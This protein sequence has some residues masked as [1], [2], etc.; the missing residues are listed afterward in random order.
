MRRLFFFLLLFFLFS[1]N[2]AQSDS[3][4]FFL[5]KDLLD[6][7][8][9][10]EWRDTGA[11]KV[12]SASRSAKNVNDLPVP[13]YVITH[14]EIIRNH[15]TSL[16]DILKYLPGFRVSQPG[17]GET[18][19]IF[20]FRGLIGNYYT[21]ILINNVPVKPSVL[22]GMPLG[23][24]LPIRQA[25]RIEII[26]GPAAAVYGADAVTGVINIITK[27][28]EKGTF[29]R[30]DI[31][32]GEF[33]KEYINFTVGGKAGK[34]RNIMQYEFYGSKSEANFMNVDQFQE[35]IIDKE[36]FNPLYYLE[37]RGEK[38]NLGGDMYSPL[39]IT[40]D[41][42]ESHSITTD[43][44]ID[45]YYPVN[46][47]GKLTEP[48]FG[49]IPLSSNMIGTRIKLRGFT[50]SYNNMNRRM[51]SSLGRST[52]LFKYNN[53]QNFI[54]ESVQRTILSYEKKWEKFF[55]SSQ[56]S[57]LG[58]SM[59]NNSNYGVTFYPNTD[60]VYVYSASHD[61]FLEQLVIYTPIPSFEVVSGV[62]LQYSSNLPTTNYLTK[63]FSKSSYDPFLENKIEPDPLF[64]DFGLNPVT[65]YNISSFIQ[66]FYVRNKFNILA[67]LRHDKNSLYGNRFNPRLALLYKLGERT[68]LTA[69][70]GMAY[71]AP[72]S[73]MSYQSIAY[74]GGVNNDSINYVAIPNT[75]LEPEEFFSTEFGIR[76]R[77]FKKFILIFHSI[78]AKSQ[79]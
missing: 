37:Q 33:G 26:Y 53:S 31:H 48:T 9:L 45:Q 15:Y 68:T 23:D 13:I 28:A 8:N 10:I 20:Q 47:E 22:A 67:G 65:F 6:V 18:G 5:K 46:Y 69:S 2:W 60:K 3:I 66:M 61:I 35:Q 63:P 12:I 4:S 77:F 74:P 21:K 50:W 57:Y 34:N 16:A 70:A 51:H 36:A 56:L 75:D 79:I 24:Q 64:G 19:D 52:Y 58:Y 17:S 27:E 29:V 40:E 30:G 62:S 49:D 11:Y 55:S 25:E 72:A 41:I 44:F 32:I 39:E 73:S 76:R 7:E 43:E 71:L 14:E 38:I 42:L 54:S 59:D 78:I 1:E